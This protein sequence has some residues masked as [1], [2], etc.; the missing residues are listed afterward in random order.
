MP[1][2]GDVRVVGGKAKILVGGPITGSG[3]PSS[4]TATTTSTS[5]F[6]FAVT[7]PPNGIA[8][9]DS[10]LQGT[11]SVVLNLRNIVGGSNVR[12][13]IVNGLIVI[14]ATPAGPTGPTGASGSVGLTG[15]AGPTGPTGA[16]GADSTVTGPTGP[17]G[18][19]GVIGATG[20]TGST[21]AVGPTG[22][23]PDVGTMA[24]QDADDVAITGGTITA[25]LT[26]LSLDMGS[27][28]ISN[29]ADPISSS[30]AANKSFVQSMAVNFSF[31]DQP[32]AE[33]TVQMMIPRALQLDF[34]VTNPLTYCITAATI[35]AEFTLQ[36]VRSAITTTIGT[37][38]FE[39]GASSATLSSPTVAN[40]VVDDILQLVTP[41]LQDATLADVVV[42]LVLTRQ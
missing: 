18:P 1:S 13:S 41:T 16:D 5:A 6:S 34:G 39:I 8:L 33:Q 30:D 38:T 3:N 42:T 40:L 35:D 20:P 24:F 7:S 21:G 29:V 25:D 22:A 19:T 32:S 11:N 31:P 9:Y 23:I 27:N 14:D 26:P 2:I 17:P 28:V 37:I 10:V 36:Y 15:N 4:G 12:V